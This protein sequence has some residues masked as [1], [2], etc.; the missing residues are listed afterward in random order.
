[1]LAGPERLLLYLIERQ[2]AYASQGAPFGTLFHALLQLSS[3]LR[4]S[5]CRHFLR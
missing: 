4:Q 1:M 5:A 2:Y 3:P